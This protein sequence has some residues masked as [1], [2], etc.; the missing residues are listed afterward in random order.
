MNSPRD[1]APAAS[2]DSRPTTARA[3]PL[4]RTGTSP[5]RPRVHDVREVA[6]TLFAER[7]YHGT[8][9]SDIAAV[10]G[11][12]VPTLYSH[13]RSK[14]ELL[15]DIAVATTEAVLTDFELATDGVADMSE[16]LRRAIEAYALR[17]ATHP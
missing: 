16:R 5:R 9:M 8:S 15:A 14:Q 3:D 1:L 11:V 7:G 17:H 10:L 12:R 2:T 13:I 4:A 6:L